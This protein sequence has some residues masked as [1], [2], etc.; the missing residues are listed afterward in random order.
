MAAF[1][2]MVPYGIASAAAVRVGQAVGR[3]DGRSASVAGWTAIL[4]GVGFMSCAA[5]AFFLAPRPLLSL[6]TNDNGVIGIGV[7]LL[8]VAA[9]FQLFDGL[10]AVTTGAL[11]GVADTRTP[12]LWN[13]TGHWLFGLPLGYT[14][15]FVLNRGV[16]GL[17]W[18][19]P[20]GLMVCGVALLVTWGRASAL[21]VHDVRRIH[22]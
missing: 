12:M 11:R 13:L 1:T 10:Q 6:F 9:V 3:D 21:L 15:C 17:W 18:G 7:T 22:G 2:F 5:A 19:L 8:F 20:A 14:L 4:I 16:P